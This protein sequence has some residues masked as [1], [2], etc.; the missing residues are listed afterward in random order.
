MAWI[1][2]LPPPYINTRRA[3]ARELDIN[4]QTRINCVCNFFG[5]SRPPP[6]SPPSLLLRFVMINSKSHSFREH[7]KRERVYF[8]THTDHFAGND[9]NAG[10]SLHAPTYYNMHSV[11][12]Y[13]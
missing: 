13:M 4:V 6:P 9:Y 11:C 7:E 2:D 8:R 10:V 3:R 5:A 12:T 1:G